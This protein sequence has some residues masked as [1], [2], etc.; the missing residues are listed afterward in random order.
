MP[1]LPWTPWHKVVQLR[2][3]LKSGE[4]PLHMSAADLYEVLSC[5]GTCRGRVYDLTI[6]GKWEGVKRATSVGSI[7]ET[8]SLG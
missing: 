3:D 8:E 4:P 2:E 5:R 6:P 7:Y 1:E